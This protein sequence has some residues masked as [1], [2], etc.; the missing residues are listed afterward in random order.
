[1]T[2][3][4][5]IQLMRTERDYLESL[6]LADMDLNR[7]RT[8]DEDV[9]EKEIRQLTA[10][11]TQSLSALCAIRHLGSASIS[12]TVAPGTRSFKLTQ[13]QYDRINQCVQ[14]WFEYN[15]QELKSS[16]E[17]DEARQ[18]KHERRVLR[19]ILRSLGLS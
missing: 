13:A 4:K 7:Q 18:C 12:R 3:P 6:L 15:R 11:H 16:P 9:G 14:N 8:G 1:M 19:S 2:K 5:I 10:E 17:D